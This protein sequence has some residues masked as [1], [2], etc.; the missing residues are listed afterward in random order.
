MC[1]RPPPPNPSLCLLPLSLGQP[2]VPADKF[3]STEV[4]TP[5]NPASAGTS[6]PT[7]YSSCSTPHHSSDSLGD[8]RLNLR[9]SDWDLFD[10]STT[11]GSREDEVS[12]I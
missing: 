4:Q 2:S 11:T 6:N 12:W 10:A 8:S 9:T 1:H 5:L 3:Q 7:P